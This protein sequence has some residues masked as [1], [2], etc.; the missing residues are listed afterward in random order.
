MSGSGVIAVP[1]S[2]MTFEGCSHSLCSAKLG[3]HYFPVNIINIMATS[4]HK[5]LHWIQDPGGNVETKYGRS[6]NSLV[7]S[8]AWDSSKFYD[9]VPPLARRRCLFKLPSQELEAI[10]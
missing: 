2:M 10:C 1:P 9:S 7:G 4:P 3:N 5:P 6:E 8:V